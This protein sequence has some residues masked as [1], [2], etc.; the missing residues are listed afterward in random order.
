MM[1]RFQLVLL[2]HMRITFVLDKLVFSSYMCVC[3][4]VCVCVYVCMYICCRMVECTDYLRYFNVGYHLHFY[5]HEIIRS[6]IS[7]YYNCIYQAS[8]SDDSFYR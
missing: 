8:V 3:V 2:I 7:T 6:H 5:G 4:C 1:F